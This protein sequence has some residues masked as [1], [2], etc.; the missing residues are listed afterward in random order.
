FEATGSQAVSFSGFVT[1]DAL[2]MTGG[3]LGADAPDIGEVKF[4]FEGA[5]D[6][7]GVRF[8][9]TTLRSVYARMDVGGDLPTEGTGTLNLEG[10]VQLAKLANAFPHTLKIQQG[11]AL[12]SGVLDIRAALSTAGKTL[13][14]DAEATIDQLAGTLTDTNGQTRAVSL[15]DAVTVKVKGTAAEKDLNIETLSLVSSFLNGS[16]SGNLDKLNITLDARLAEALAE[17][18]KF[19]DLGPLQAKGDAHL[20]L[21]MH[22]QADDDRKLTLDVSSESLFFAKGAQVLLPRQA[23]ALGVI[24]NTDIPEA[25]FLSV[26][27]TAQI[28][29]QS[30]LANGRIT[31]KN[32]VLP[33]TEGDQKTPMTFGSLGI[34]TTINLDMLSAMLPAPKEGDP[35]VLGGMA[36]LSGSL[37]QEGGALSTEKFELRAKKFSYQKGPQQ[38]AQDELVLSTGISVDPE[39]KQAVLTNLSTAFGVGT[40]TAPSITIANWED[41]VN[42][43]TAAVNAQIDIQKT[44]VT[45]ASFT[46]A[47][48][49]VPVT[50]AA[51]LNLQMQPT[52]SGSILGTD[53]TISNF[54][55]RMKNDKVIQEAVV[56]L[57]GQVALA[58]DQSAVQVNQMS[59]QTEPFSLSGTAAL[60]DLKTNGRVTAKGAFAYD[61][62]KITPY[63]KMFTGQDIAP[64]G[65][66]DEPF[67]LD[68]PLGSK[69]GEV[70]APGYF[71]SGFNVD[72]LVMYGLDIRNLDIPLVLSNQQF[73]ASIEAGLNEG[74]LRFYPTVRLDLPKP[75][76]T[77]P[78]NSLVLSQIKLNNEVSNDL[79]GKIHPLF[80]GA[81]VGN[82]KM[83]LTMDYLEVPTG[84]KVMDEIRFAGTIALTNVQLA[85]SGMLDLLMSVIQAKEKEYMLK[86]QDITFVAEKGRITCSPLTFKAKGR[87]VVLHGSIGFDQTVAYLVSLPV[88]EDL[89]GKEA[90]KFL[91]GQ[92][93]SVPI[94]GTVSKPKIDRAAFQSEVSGLVKGALKKGA[95]DLL[96]KEAGKFL[97][98]FLNKK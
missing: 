79:L 17:A 10:N 48:E 11:L 21:S 68:F 66:H 23:I 26:V 75:T 36:T 94:G 82:G 73:S 45:V 43:L 9:E 64:I 65:K 27:K 56:K 12:E 49:V 69:T 88:T 51:V 52:D 29:M 60:K 93:I 55:Y 95:T 58:R 72:Q 22:K 97:D 1:T 32:M 92:F 87:D 54:A 46:G 78:T 19:V 5:K 8:K 24:A 59:F 18:S 38:Y 42:T 30:Q 89:V 44:M 13:G 39:K 83:D 34:G 28:S 84:D 25:G 77:I 76:L 37:Q 71:K 4:V 50:G 3:A 85:T 74:E 20:V 47:K 16:G 98:G 7:A 57:N 2:K 91:E 40:I 53:L 86:H 70:Q 62:V 6:Q 80:K 96:Q 14:V 33:K 31:A 41:A 15:G 63:I 81:S 90:F 61:L 67:V 35:M